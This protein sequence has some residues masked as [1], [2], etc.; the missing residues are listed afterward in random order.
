MKKIALFFLVLGI[1]LSCS[2]DI[3][4]VSYR[5]SYETSFTVATHPNTL[6][7]DRDNER[8][9]V[10]CSP[11]YL[12]DDYD[13]KIVEYNQDGVIQSTVVD[14]SEFTKGIFDLYMPIDLALDEEH[15]LYALCAPFNQETDST[16][17]GTHGFSILKFD[18]GNQFKREYDFSGQEFC[19]FATSMAYHAGS[20]YVMKC[21]ILSKIDVTSGQADDIFISD[22]EYANFSTAFA[23]DMEINSQGDVYLTG[24]AAF[25]HESVG[26][27]IMKL[28]LSGTHHTTFFSEKRTSFVAANIGQPGLGLDSNGDVY[29][30]SFYS[31]TLELF[32][33]DNQFIGMLEFG[34]EYCLPIDVAVDNKNMYIADTMNDVIYI[35][36]KIRR[37]R[38]E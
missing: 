36:K 17:S 37:G 29:L 10:S 32:D 12:S 1:S 33:R 13:G 26:C 24:Q 25:N 7:V 18:R 30:A 5:Y 3:S 15:N 21:S 8:L 31:K 19:S 6:I 28:N 2:E 38:V 11:Q 16:W 9:F 35:Y 27:F 14:F 22:N 34:Q 4:P 23:T 20:L